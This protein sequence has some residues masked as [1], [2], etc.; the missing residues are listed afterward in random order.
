[1]PESVF[2]KAFEQSK[3]GPGSNDPIFSLVERR[4]DFGVPTIKEP[5]FTKDTRNDYEG[6]NLY[7][8]PELPKKNRLIF[9]YM[10][11]TDHQPAH[12]PDSVSNPGRW[13]YYDVDLDAVREQLT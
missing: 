12:M 7:L 2:H 3:V 4:A 11:K 8:V 13:K 1:M 5:Y 9:K 10:P 6:D